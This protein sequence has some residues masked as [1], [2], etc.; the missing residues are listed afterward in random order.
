MTK[1]RAPGK[2]PIILK[3]TRPNLGVE[4]EYYAQLM[5][6]IEAM[7]KSVNFWIS[8]EYKKNPPAMAQDATPASALRAAMRK[9]GRRWITQ[10][11]E[12]AENLATK[13]ADKVETVSSAGMMSELKRVGFAVKF[14]PSP[15]VR[16]AY[17]SVIGENVA[18]IKSIP[19][20]YLA[21][22]E[23]DIMR[24]VQAGR[25]LKQLSDDLQRRFEMT[26]RRA[27]F[28]AKDQN[29]KATAVMTKARRMTLGI[30]KAVW[31]HSGGGVHPR[32]SH[33]RASRDKL[34]YDIAQ[35]AYIDGEYIMPGEKPNCRC[36][37]RAVIPGFDDDDDE[38]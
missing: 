24:S 14:K 16:D 30:T 15:D 8:A 22:V 6:L 2:N 28:I 34:T 20:K 32:E 23:G 11:N 38:D 21:D 33:V 26:K 4:A 19:Q 18:L 5:K 10:F 31:V 9:L 29:N 36:T 37:S 13:F 1:L 17:S 35:G 25:D 3:P 7:S 27:A 12:A